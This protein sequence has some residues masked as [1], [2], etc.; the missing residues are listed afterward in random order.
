MKMSVNQLEKIRQELEF[1]NDT[2]KKEHA[3]Y[4]EKVHFEFTKISH[5]D[6]KSLQRRN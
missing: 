6:F 1:T 3:E 5:L 4:K 2:L